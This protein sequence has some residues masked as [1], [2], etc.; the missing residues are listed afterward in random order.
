MPVFCLVH[1]RHC[2]SPHP[3]PSMQVASDILGEKVIFK[4]QNK[5]HEGLSYVA[6]AALELDT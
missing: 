4:K 6:L 5:T 1:P 2:H 3:L